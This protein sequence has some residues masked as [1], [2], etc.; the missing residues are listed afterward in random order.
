MNKT[1]QTLLS[2]YPIEIIEKQV[3]LYYLQKNNINYSKC[4]T[5]NKY[6]DN[7]DNNFIIQNALKI[8]SFN[9]ITTLENILEIL[10]PEEDKKLNGAFFTPS[11]IVD[12]IINQ[13]SPN[14][15]HKNID[16]SCGCGAFLLGLLDYYTKN[17]NK[18]IKEIIQSNIFGA[19]ILDYNVKRTKILLT[20]YAL[21]K[22]EIIDDADFNLYNRDSLHGS[23]TEQFDNVIGNP[24]YVRFQDLSEVNRNRL[25]KWKTIQNGS[26]NLYFAFFELGYSLLKENGNLGYIT[27]N[28]YF[29]SIAAESLRK[30]FHDNKCVKRIVDF[31]H[32]KIFNAQTYTA[33]TFLSKTKNEIIYYD[34]I[35]DLQTSESFLKKTNSSP[36]EISKLNFKK[37]RLLNCDEQNNIKNIETIG[38]PISKLFNISVGIATLKDDLYFIDSKREDENYYYKTINNNIFAIEKKI[39]KEIYKISDFKRQNDLKNNDRRIIFPYNLK[40]NAAIVISESDMFKTFPKCYEYFIFVKDK[41]KERDKGKSIYEPFYAYGRTQGLTKKGKKILTP[42]FSRYPRFLVT[43]NEDS[44][45]CNGYGIYFNTNEDDLLFDFEENLIL[46]SKNIFLLQKI[47]NSYVMHYYI[48]NTSVSIEGGYPC[49]QKN[50]IEKFSIPHFNNQELIK[51]DNLNDEEEINNFLIKKYQLN[52]SSPNLAEYIESRSSTKDVK[53]ISRRVACE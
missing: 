12:F 45:F 20:I 36:N 53:S 11:F 21:Q 41:L 33:I 10:I 32:K 47:L 38:I 26:F 19:D 46:N 22:N 30:Y 31:K 7:I 44:L 18:P 6:L 13:I 35:K 37:W 28:N 42:T 23:W 4:T 40:N 34:K 39:T 51:L 17:F 49:Y 25:T 48:S 24:P 27:P 2:Q 9:S 15:N 16:P 1:I 43:L 8:D 14:I 5:L 29:T 3:I 50:F 52:L